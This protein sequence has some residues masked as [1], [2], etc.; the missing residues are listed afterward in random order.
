MGELHLRACRVARPDPIELAGRLVALELTS[1]LDAFHRAAVT[2]AEVLGEAGT[3][4]NATT[5]DSTARL[6]PMRGLNTDR[7]A[8][9]IINGHAFIQNVRRGHYELGADVRHDQ[10]RVAA[11]FDEHATTI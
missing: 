7:T 5:A 6:R 2:Y 11:A 3:G 8:R 9:V 4:S 1:E 10:L